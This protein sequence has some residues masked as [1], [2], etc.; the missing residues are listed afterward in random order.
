MAGTRRV[1]KLQVVVVTAAR[2]IIDDSTDVESVLDMDVDVTGIDREL[3]TRIAR[4]IREAANQ[5]TNAEEPP[6]AAGDDSGAS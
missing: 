3:P 6:F 4:A 2:G 5:P 1:L